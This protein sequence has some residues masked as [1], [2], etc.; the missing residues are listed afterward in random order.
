MQN[1]INYF[2]SSQRHVQSIQRRI[3]RKF[4]FKTGQVIQLLAKNKHGLSKKELLTFFC[5][6]FDSA[7]IVRRESIKM[8][9][10]KVIQR[11]RV[12]FKE[13]KITIIFNKQTK[14]YLLQV[15]SQ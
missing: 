15:L 7:S 9:A 8:S 10:E 6:N 5:K 14:R 4:K 12:A 13:N 2:L 11:A 3:P 1:Q